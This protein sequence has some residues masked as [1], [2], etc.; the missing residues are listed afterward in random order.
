MAR[1]SLVYLLQ[2]L[3]FLINVKK[4]VL[5][6][7]STLEFLGVDINSKGMNLSSGE[8]EQNTGAVLI[9]SVETISA[10]QRV[11]SGYKRP[12]INSHWS[13]TYASTLSSYA[14]SADTGVFHRGKLQFSKKI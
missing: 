8:Q 4:S 13:S 1:D 7:C 9:P 6:P 10:Y 14:A 3:G 12:D 11:D 2:C 5:P